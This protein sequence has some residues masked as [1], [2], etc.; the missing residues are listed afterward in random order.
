MIQCHACAFYRRTLS[1]R[2]KPKLFRLSAKA[3]VGTFPRS[4]I[5]IN[6]FVWISVYI[7][8]DKLQHFFAPALTPLV[9][10]SYCNRLL[11]FLRRNS[12]NT[13]TNSCKPTIPP[14]FVQDSPA[15]SFFL[16]S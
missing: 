5:D 8:P 2:Q 12:P 13:N 15:P 9:L 10:R 4:I 1:I 3:A 6:I 14:L 7:L 11:P 16:F